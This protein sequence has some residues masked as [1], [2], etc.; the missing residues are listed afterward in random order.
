MES[1]GGLGA[2]NSGDFLGSIG[3]EDTFSSFLDCLI[4]DNVFGSQ[5]EPQPNMVAP[6]TQPFVS[7]SEIL[8]IHNASIWENE[9]S[10]ATLTNIRDGTLN[11]HPAA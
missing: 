4:D 7:P 10:M 3:N 2:S 11:N 1:Q 6:S 8:D 9:V 5:Q